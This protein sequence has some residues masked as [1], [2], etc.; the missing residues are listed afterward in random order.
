MQSMECL[1]CESCQDV[2]WSEKRNKVAAAAAGGLFA[3][4]AWFAID[5]SVTDYNN[6]NDLYH[7]CGVFS[8]LSLVMVNTVNNSQ[9]QGDSMYEGGL[10]GGAA[11]K[12]WFFFGL[13]MGFG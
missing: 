4:G 13:L 12:I 9:L 3:A 10:L 5:A 2:E 1:P 11:A 7:L 6:T 8:F